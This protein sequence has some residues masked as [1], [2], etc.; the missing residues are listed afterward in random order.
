MDE[1]FRDLGQIVVDDVRDV[2]HVNAAR[3]QVGRHQNAKAP[4]LKSS[5]GRGA[6]GLRAVAMDHGGGKAFAIQVLGQALGAALGAGEYKAAA[7]FFR[8]QAVQHLLFAVSGDFKGL[9]A[10]VFRRLQNR[11]E[12]QTYRVSACSR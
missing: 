11:A 4:L 3:R 1:V 12:G 5:Q 9:N 10:Y 6:L 7:G 8:Q 2:L